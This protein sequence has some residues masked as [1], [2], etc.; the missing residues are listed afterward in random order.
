MAAQCFHGPRFFSRRL[1]K[2]KRFG[3]RE[4]TGRSVVRVPDRMP[5]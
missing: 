4:A 5:G 1:E 3:H 2:I